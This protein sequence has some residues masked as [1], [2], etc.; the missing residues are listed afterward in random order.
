MTKK[1]AKPVH[2]SQCM[3]V[4]NEEANIEKALSWGKEVAYEQIVV[5][6]GSTDRTVELAKAMGAK[7]YSFEWI[8]DFAAAKNFAISKASGDWIAFLDADEVFVPGDEKK[9]MEILKQ[10][11]QFQEE[12]DITDIVFVSRLE[13]ND[14]G[15]VF[16][17]ITLPR[18]FRNCS[19]LE[20]HGRI[21]ERLDWKDG[22]DMIAVDVSDK[23]FIRH[24]GYQEDEI[25]EKN[26]VQRNERLILRELEEH[27]DDFDMMGYLGDVYLVDAQNEKAIEW[28]QKAVDAMPEILNE[29]DQRSAI[30][31]TNLMIALGQDVKNE[32]RLKKTYQ[33]AIARL[34]EEPDFDYIYGKN[35]VKWKQFDEAKRYLQQAFGKLEHSNQSGTAFNRAVELNGNLA[36]AFFN[37][38]KCCAETGEIN[39]AITLCVEILKADSSDTRT[40]GLLLHVFRG[41]GL[42]PIV[43]PEQTVEFLKKICDF[44]SLRGRYLV[45]YAAK[46]ASYPELAHYME[47][48]FSPE[49]KAGLEKVGL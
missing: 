39:R 2:L 46:E 42:A 35:L 21:H 7:V 28:Y 15:K 34:P 11:N 48:L 41:N 5:D 25:G 6:T 38:A 36:D 43:T 22:H 40:L 4:K 24:S 3:I 17:S 49:E 20:Y 16:G 12:G 47:R 32:Q 26:K 13:I 10:L 31:F 37:L 8:D 14:T 1:K 9:L 44:N 23:I 33:T 18:I 19:G 30:T 45:L 27:P 29:R